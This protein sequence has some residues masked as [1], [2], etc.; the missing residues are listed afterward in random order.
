MYEIVLRTKKSGVL[1]FWKIWSSTDYDQETRSFLLS[2]LFSIGC[3]AISH[4]LNLTAG[5]VHILR[6]RKGKKDERL[7]TVLFFHLTN[8]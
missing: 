2:A 1:R 6:T 3:V 5:N 7:M 4:S 8:L